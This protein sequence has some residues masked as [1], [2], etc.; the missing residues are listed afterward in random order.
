MRPTG[1]EMVCERLLALPVIADALAVPGVTGTRL[2][3]VVELVAARA[4]PVGQPP[5]ER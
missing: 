4:M 1:R 2:G 5:T 3:A